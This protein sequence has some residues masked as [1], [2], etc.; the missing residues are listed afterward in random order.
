MIKE[1]ALPAKIFLKFSL[2]SKDIIQ[3]MFGI[4]IF[5]KLS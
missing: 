3:Y 1:K 2:I 4:G 5:H